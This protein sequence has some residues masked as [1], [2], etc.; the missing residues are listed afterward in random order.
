MHKGTL[1]QRNMKLVCRF[2]PLL[3]A[4]QPFSR[5]LTYQ[6]TSLELQKTLVLTTTWPL[7]H[8]VVDLGRVLSSIIFSRPTSLKEV[9]QYIG[10]AQMLKKQKQ[11][12]I[13][14]SF[15]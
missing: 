12:I 6:T 10:D 7:S 13:S 8:L 1:T 4:V 2:V 15:A 3:L 9:E 5:F 14:N 11:I